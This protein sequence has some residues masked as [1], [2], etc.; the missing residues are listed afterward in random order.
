MLSLD[1]MLQEESTAHT[2]TSPSGSRQPQ[3]G[4]VRWLREYHYRNIFVNID[5]EGM[6][7]GR[8][9]ASQR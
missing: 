3:T 9:G 1:A 5:D 4:A 8:A 2:K 7:T 6:T